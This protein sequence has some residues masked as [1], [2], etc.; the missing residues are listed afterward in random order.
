M[1]NTCRK[2]D[3][4]N[5]TSSF[6]GTNAPWCLCLQVERALTVARDRAAA[7][8]A[9]MSEFLHVDATAIEDS[10]LA[11]RTFDVLLDCGV[12]HTFAGERRDKW[13]GWKGGSRSQ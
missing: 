1:S 3:A 8:A 6:D 12:Y 2:K 11:G 13:V 9:P 5:S 10:T 4:V 7:A